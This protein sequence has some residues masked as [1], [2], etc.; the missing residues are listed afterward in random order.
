[1]MPPASEMLAPI[2]NA[3]SARLQE[4]DEVGVRVKEMEGKKVG[5]RSRRKRKEEE[6]GEEKEGE[7]ERRRTRK[8]SKKK[9]EEELRMKEWE[10]KMQKQNK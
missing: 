9:P 6:G 5:C 8:E 10:E 7:G 4:N 2:Y 1:M 3:K